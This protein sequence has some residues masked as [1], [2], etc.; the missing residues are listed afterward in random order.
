MGMGENENM[1]EVM[2]LDDDKFE[3]IRKIYVESFPEKI[4]ELRK[5]WAELDSVA[6][7]NQPL[8]ELRVEVHKIAGSSGSHEFNDIYALAKEVENKIVRVLDE[9][10]SWTNDKQE[11]GNLVQQ[12][13]DMFEDELLN[14]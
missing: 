14:Y 2:P 3:R 11:I 7:Y 10:S 6:E 1:K 8:S 5:C 13:V 12:L 4:Q 9:K